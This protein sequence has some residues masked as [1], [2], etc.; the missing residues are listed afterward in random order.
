MDSNTP[1]LIS[2]R[3]IAKY[4]G[5]SPGMIRYLKRKHDDFPRPEFR[6]GR[7]DLYEVEKIRRWATAHDRPWDE[8]NRSWVVVNLDGDSPAAG[9]P[10]KTVTTP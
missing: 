6:V 10:S 7:T 8:S 3:Q 2:G 4:L 9:T 5:L 1:H